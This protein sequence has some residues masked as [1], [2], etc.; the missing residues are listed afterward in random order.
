MAGNLAPG[1][2]LLRY[3]CSFPSRRSFLCSDF[4]DLG[5]SL[6]RLL[7]ISLSFRA[8]KDIVSQVR[9]E[10][11]NDRRFVEIPLLG[12]SLLFFRMGTWEWR[13]IY[14]DEEQEH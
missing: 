7:S 5:L 9:M 4:A 2:V 1:D 6:S 12:N 8:G 11:K 13:G 14:F 10:W 3:V